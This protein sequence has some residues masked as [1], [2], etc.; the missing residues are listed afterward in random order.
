MKSSALSAV[1]KILFLIFLFSATQLYSQENSLSE[2][3]LS[4]AEDLASDES[5]PEAIA[6]FI[7]RLHELAENPVNLNSA[8]EEE[9]SDLFFLSDFQ[10]KALADYSHSSGKIYSVYEIAN[11]PGFDKETAAMLLPF[12]KLE[13]VTEGQKSPGKLRNTL[14]TNLSFK[15][16]GNDTSSQGSQMKLLSKYRF[17][18]G[19]FSGGFSAEKDAGEKLFYGNPPKPDFASAY[20]SYTGKGFIKKLIIGDFSAKLGQGTNVNT[21]MRT[22]LSLTGMGYSS[23]GNQIKEYTSTDENNFF[24]GVAAELSIK[25][26]SM[27]LYYSRNNIDATTGSFSDSTIDHVESLYTSGLHNTVSMQ[28][29]RD[30]LTET[31]TG[32]NLSYNFTKVRLGLTV[33]DEHLSLPLIKK[34]GD[35]EDVY[36]FSGDHSGSYSFYYNALI[37]KLILFGE[38][39]IDN[40]GDNALVQGLTMRVSDRL[41]LNSMY[42]N[43]Q[44]GYFSLHGRGPGSSSSGWNENSIMGNFTFEAAKHL[45]ISAGADIRHYPWLKYRNSAPSRGIREE[46]RI[47]YLPSDNLTFEILYNY[48]M[49]MT[50]SSTEFGIPQQKELK[51]RSLKGSLKYSPSENLTL[52]MRADYKLVNSQG[53]KGMLISQDAS[54]KF[55]KIPVT[56]WFR[57]CLFNTGNWDSRIYTYENDLLYSFSIPALSGEGN[58]SYFMIKY[59]PGDRIDFRVK[60]GITSIINGEDLKDKQ[61]F[62]F[63]FRV[64]F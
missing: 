63:Q 16:G 36:D 49:S 4:I 39:S 61:E 38:F 43:Y 13:T 22:G 18:S 5:D 10:I 46:I 54:Y 45:F 31:S 34:A 2:I 52:G 19:G 57:Y 21:A 53:G 12:I 9:L 59:E 3:I 44:S 8:D 23:P 55:R 51:T 32:M 17:T 30:A 7:D 20:V 62:K 25:N 37:S 1:K 29:K 15:P 28:Q 24:R 60:Y 58:R 56:L 48:R 33:S 47:K 41:T 27:I 40:S 64:L 50:D 26:L 35:P 42:R 14:L 6:S 11:I